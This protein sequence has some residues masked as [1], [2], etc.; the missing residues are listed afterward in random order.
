MIDVF[1]FYI[2]QKVWIFRYYTVFSGIITI[3]LL[4][5]KTGLF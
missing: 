3:F 1:F 4:D 5:I 2:S